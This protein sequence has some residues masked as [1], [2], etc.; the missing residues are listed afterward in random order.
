MSEKI[1][2]RCDPEKHRECR[3]RNCFKQ[4]GPCKR[5]CREECAETDAEGKPIIEP[6]WRIEPEQRGQADGTD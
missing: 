6:G 5:T 3:K 1:W 2:Y 4:G